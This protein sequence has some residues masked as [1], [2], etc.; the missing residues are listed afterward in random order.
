MP[1]T[2]TKPELTAKASMAQ[3]VSQPAVYANGLSEKCKATSL[4]ALQ[5][6]NHQKM[7]IIEED[8]DVISQL[9]EGEHIVGIRCYVRLT[10]SSVHTFRGNVDRTKKVPSV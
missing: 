10:Q 5:V 2:D 9:E 3:P 8:L 6:K 4:S 7:V 1:S